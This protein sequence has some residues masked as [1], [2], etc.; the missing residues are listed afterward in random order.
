M[1]GKKKMLVVMY[2][3]LSM[4]EKEERSDQVRIVKAVSEIQVAG[5]RSKK[6]R[7]E[8]SQ[9]L[10]GVPIARTLFYVVAI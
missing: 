6:E 1:S 7:K 10:L 5:K 3:S 2:K 4:A 8:K 9:V